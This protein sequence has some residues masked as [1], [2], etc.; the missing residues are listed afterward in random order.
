MNGKNEIISVLI[1]MLEEVRILC[2]QLQEKCRMRLV[3]SFFVSQTEDTQ[4]CQSACPLV[5][6]ENYYIFAFLKRMS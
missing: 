3:I 6:E 5:A 2:F 1:S 4:M